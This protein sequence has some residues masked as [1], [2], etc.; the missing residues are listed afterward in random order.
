MWNNESR[1]GMPFYRNVEGD[2][3]LEAE[4]SNGDDQSS[5]ESPSAEKIKVTCFGV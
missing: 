1:Y 2:G 3:S 4:I 5:G